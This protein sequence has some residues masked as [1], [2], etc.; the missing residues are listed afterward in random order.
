MEQAF[1][2]AHGYGIDEYQHDPEKIV[3]VEQRRERDYSNSQR[4]VSQMERQVHRD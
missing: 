1:R 3:E 2:S 4:I